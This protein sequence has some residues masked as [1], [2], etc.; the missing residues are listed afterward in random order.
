MTKDQ[1]IETCRK[2]LVKKFG[3]AES[4]D[5]PNSKEFAENVVICLE[6]LGL[7]KPSK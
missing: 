7:L 6:A 2:A 1:A 3:Y 4:A 5:V